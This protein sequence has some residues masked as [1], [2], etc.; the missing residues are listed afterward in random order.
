MTIDSLEARL[1]QLGD[2][3]DRDGRRMERELLRTFDAAHRPSA[4]RATS[5]RAPRPRVMVAA[6]LA[7]A[8]IAAT[9][10]WL[11]TRDT[12]GAKT[13]ISTPATGVAPD[14]S[15]ACAAFGGSSTKPRSG[16]SARSAMIRHIDVQA[17]GCGTSVYFLAG[18]GKWNVRYSSA[19]ST[20]LIARLGGAHAY[21]SSG[22]GFIPDTYELDRPSAVTEMHRM[23]HQNDA[24][25]PGTTWSIQLDERRRFTAGQTKIGGTSVFAV[26][27]DA[28]SDG[29]Q[30]RV[31]PN[32][33]ITIPSGWFADTLTPCHAL[34]PEP[35]ARKPFVGDS[36]AV[37]LMTGLKVEHIQDLGGFGGKV[38]QHD[39]GAFTVNGRPATRTVFTNT[40]PDSGVYE[41]YQVVIQWDS[42]TS[43]VISG[44]TRPFPPN[45]P[46][47]SP[48]ELTEL[49]GVVDAIANSAAPVP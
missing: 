33:D 3:L 8:V 24:D 49:Q 20:T 32:I 23:R 46:S 19:T 26:N 35:I 45:A 4:T 22:G 11:A 15:T 12:D 47:R 21:D 14:A 36:A 39:L 30:C 40:T 27:I 5:T 25:D 10:G 31:A 18:A 6:A 44:V 7:F 13:R 43:L 17:S 28:P 34:S 9:T 1:E 38:E 29:L 16:R 41:E 48:V 2:R 42:E 37:H